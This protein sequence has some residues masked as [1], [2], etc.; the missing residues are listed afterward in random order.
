M[1]FLFDVHKTSCVGMSCLQ[2]I[3]EV[4]KVATPQVG[5]ET[6]GASTCTRFSL[7]AMTVLSSQL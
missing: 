6:T 1:H 3:V 7:E 2:A 5:L 4:L